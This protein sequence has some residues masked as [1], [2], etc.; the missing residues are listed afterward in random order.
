[1]REENLAEK[2]IKIYDEWQLRKFCP[3]NNGNCRDD[4]NFFVGSS[5]DFDMP[6]IHADAAYCKL[7]KK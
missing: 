4:C 7:E 1:M 3:F 6:E 2:R 5:I